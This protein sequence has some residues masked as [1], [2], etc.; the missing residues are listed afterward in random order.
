MRGAS[1][2]QRHTGPATPWL[3]TRFGDAPLPASREAQAREWIALLGGVVPVL[4]RVQELVDAGNPQLACH[5][6]EFAV[7]ADPSDEVHALRTRAYRSW[8][9]MQE[10]WMARSILAHAALSSEHGERD[11]ARARVPAMDL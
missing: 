3:R 10:S 8:S 6:I 4:K 9:Q 11:L 5:L 7:L 1:S 2:T